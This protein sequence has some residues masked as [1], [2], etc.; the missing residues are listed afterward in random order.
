MIEKELI[1]L[2]STPNAVLKAK[3]VEP[4]LEPPYQKH[5]KPSARWQ[6]N[7]AVEEMYNWRR[8]FI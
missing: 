8:R 5:Y 3:I 1:G 4:R 6:H 2:M 7:S